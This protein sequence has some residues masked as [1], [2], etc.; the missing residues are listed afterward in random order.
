[1]RPNKPQLTLR[2]GLHKTWTNP[3]I[4]ASLS[5]AYVRCGLYKMRR[6][7]LYQLFACFASCV[8]NILCK[9]LL[10]WSRI[11]GPIETWDKGVCPCNDWALLQ[12]C[13]RES[14]LVILL[15]M[16][17]SLSLHELF[18][19]LFTAQP[20]SGLLQAAVITLYTMYLTWSA[21]SNEPGTL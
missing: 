19:T 16:A 12:E 3:F 13:P 18:F 6:K 9:P 15:C 14:W 10:I 2:R 17:A 7:F 1:M 11:N 4:R 8:S 5:V 21:M 20:G